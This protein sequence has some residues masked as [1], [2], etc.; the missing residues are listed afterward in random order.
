MTPFVLWHIYQQSLEEI[1]RLERLALNS[2]GATQEYRL[3][4]TIKGVGPILG[5]MIGLETGD[6]H[7]FA[8][9]GNVR[10]VLPLRE[11]RAAVQQQEKRR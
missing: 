7:R 6:I 1:D 5:L 10:F 8:S 2:Y 3:L 9:A 4:T 11:R